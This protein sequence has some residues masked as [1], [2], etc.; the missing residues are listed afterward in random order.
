MSIR[1]S[2]YLSII[3]SAIFPLIF[4]TILTYMISYNKYSQL[5]KTSAADLANTYADGFETHINLQIAE[6]EGLANV[7]SIQ[8]IVLES[9]NGVAMGQKSKYYD[10]VQQLLS[11][12]SIYTNNTV[13][14]YLYDI[15][16]YY[17]ASTDNSQTAD[18][19]EYMNISVSDVSHTQ[20]LKSSNIN[21]N[22]ES[23]EIVSPIKVKDI[24][25]GLLRVN[26]DSSYFGAFIPN[27][28]EAFIMTE[29]GDYLFSSTGFSN[30]EMEKAALS[31]LIHKKQNGYISKNKS[32]VSN[33]YGYKYIEAF[34]WL[35]IIKQEGAQYKNLVSTLPTTLIFT[36]VILIIY[37]VIICRILAKRYTEPIYVLNENMKLASSGDLDVA[38]QITSNDEFGEL[39]NSF[40]NM[41][42]IISSNYKE[43]DASKKTL[44]DNEKELRKNYAHIE[45]LAYHDSLTGLY[46]RVAFLKYAYNIFHENGS[47]LAKHAIFFLDLDNFK[48]VNDT[49]G[50]D[51]GDLLLKNVSNILTENISENDLLARTGGDEFLILKNSYDTIDELNEFAKKIVTLIRR[52]FLLDDEYASISLSLGISLF[53]KD[54]LT[55]SEL[56][57]NADIAMYCAKNS[58]KNSYR[59]FDSIMADDFNRKNNLAD[60]LSTVIENKEIYLLYQPQINVI[61]GK[62]TG[63]E[64]LM[65]INSKLI[66]NISP[67][68]FIPIAEDN[69]IINKLGDWALYEACT[70]N[71]NLI[72]LGYNDIK[73]SVNV[74]TSQLKDDHLITIIDSIPE[75]TGMSLSNLELEITESVLMTAI[76]H[77]LELI[78]KFKEKGISIALDDFGTGYSSF[79]YLTQ[80]PI[81][82]L[83]IDKSF[84]DR[85]CD[86]DKDQII[87]D[88]I[89]SLSHN[90]NISVVAE[91]V[92]QNDQYNILKTQKCDTIQGYYYSKPLTAEEF[93][94]F[95]Q[96][97]N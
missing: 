82:T 34:N 36:V 81:D 96:R 29:N 67:T 49:L 26:I 66:G 54:G 4:M 22:N 6:V 85:I 57:K 40:N 46:N 92:E 38:C 83:K 20:I 80:I 75:I 78:N 41:M 97:N 94:L 76:D 86:N 59:F 27:H 91:G 11:Q 16:G 74:S 14:Y 44:E 84:V 90:M 32:S 10:Q 69:G 8:N 50:H 17:I 18:W 42:D 35:Y 7:S 56:I 51:Y 28:G 12:T 23:I 39:S 71:N 95:L 30:E 31:N 68:E 79:N 88:S 60:I 58:G 63:Y 87:S 45:K 73:V 15:N 93:I 62:V 48:N 2:L 19:E 64:A 9:Y 1:K 5:A 25:V 72:K 65:R 21:K 47:H 55:I 89:I 13:H 43:L 37:S 52:P 53:P 3:T 24:I 61:T 70:F 33:I 77:N